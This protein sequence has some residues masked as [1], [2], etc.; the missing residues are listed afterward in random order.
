MRSPEEFRSQLE[1]L[2]AMGEYVSP[3]QLEQLL[4]RPDAARLERGFVL[5]FDDGFKDHIRYVAP[6]L[7]R[8]GWKAFFF[9]NSAHWQ[10]EMLGV[11]R[12]QLLNAS[13]QFPNLYDAFIQW[14]RDKDLALDPSQL[15]MERVRQAYSY[16]EDNVARFKFSINFEMSHDSRELVLQELF[17]QFLGDESDHMTEL[18]LTT[19]E[20][21][22][23]ADFGHTIGCHSHRHRPL[24]L[25]N[26]KDCA[27]DLA[28]N[29]QSIQE[30]TGQRPSWISFPNGV[31]DSK[32]VHTLAAC[33]GQGLRFGFTMNRG[34]IQSEARLISLNR[35]DT[36]DAPGGKSPMINW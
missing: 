34:F 13:V 24:S 16:D 36:N 20:C 18:Y 26:A 25:L 4:L 14:L 3:E 28:I 21:K 33:E 5:T 2:A 19:G 22:M 1:T 31:L 7:D 23:L 29:S 35:V 10:G 15:S 30:A 12:L 27:A 6:E 17:A 11:H 8:R 9:V 32:D